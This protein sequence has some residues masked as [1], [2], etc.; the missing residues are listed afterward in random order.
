VICPPSNTCAG[1][2]ALP[3]SLKRAHTRPQPRRV[4][5]MRFERGSGGFPS[6]RNGAYQRSREPVPAGGHSIPSSVWPRTP[7][8][9]RAE[10]NWGLP[11]AGVRVKHKLPSLLGL[12]GLLL[13]L[14]IA[15]K[16]GLLVPSSNRTSR[17]LEASRKRQEHTS[18]LPYISSGPHVLWCG[19]GRS[20]VL[21]LLTV[22]TQMR[23]KMSTMSDDTSRNQHTGEDVWL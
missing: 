22:P 5:R 21:L 19:G 13:G 16:R 18:V 23:R 14:L 2:L 1:G 20:P 11:W 4:Q 15:L 9:A 10:V 6:L 17:A 12:T 8:F 7:P 3:L